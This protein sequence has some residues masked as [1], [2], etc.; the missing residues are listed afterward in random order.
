MSRH[1]GE[2]VLYRPAYLRYRLLIESVN[3]EKSVFRAERLIVGVELAELSEQLG[4]LLCLVHV[5]S[6]KVN[7]PPAFGNGRFRN[8][9]INY[10]LLAECQ[11]AGI[12]QQQQLAWY[13]GSSS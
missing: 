10:G 3:A 7:Q 4:G 1:H 13:G 2:N 6:G 5:F 12:A 8:V 9:R 11:V